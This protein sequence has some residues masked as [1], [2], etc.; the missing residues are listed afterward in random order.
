[1]KK[2]IILF[3]ISFFNFKAFT[4]EIPTPLDSPYKNLVHPKLELTKGLPDKSDI[5]E[6]L[7]FISPVKA[8]GSRGTCS[9]FSSIAHLEAM[10]AIINKIPSDQLPNLSEEWL[11]YLQMSLKKSNDE[12]SSTPQNFKLFSSHGFISESALPY[13][14]QDWSKVNENSF[15]KNYCSNIATFYVNRQISSKEL[16]TKCLLAHGNPVLFNLD[17]TELQNHHPKFFKLKISS[18]ANLNQSLLPLSS[19]NGYY[20]GSVGAIKYLLSNGIPVSLGLEFY[21]GA[22]NH[23]KTVEYG[24]PRNM[25]LWY[26][27]IIAY[28]EK[29]SVDFQESKKHEAGHS[30]LLVGY[31]DNVVVTNTYKTVTG[32]FVTK[33]YQGVFY[34]KNSWGTDNFGLKFNIDGKK[35][36]GFGM[37][38]YKYAYEFGGFTQLPLKRKN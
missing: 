25:E 2:I 8:Q 6:I 21:Y 22:W 20:L 26:Q 3:L 27:G 34:F 17:N 19:K 16:E 24:I 9:I 30:I 1:M 38:T 14:P 12:G 4:Q 7:P 5:G 31:D 28:P 35:Y 15:Q 37:I 29:D 13:D 10:L 36:P 23:R 18:K 11:Q 32:E 33:K